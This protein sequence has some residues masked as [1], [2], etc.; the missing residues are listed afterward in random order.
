VQAVVTDGAANVT[1]AVK[2]AR[3]PHLFCFT[4]TLNLVLQNGVQLMK[5]LQDKVKTI[6]EYFHHSTVAADKLRSLQ[7][8]LRPEKQRPH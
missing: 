6:V 1:A 4:H 7:Q 2:K 8:Q 3:L 5:P